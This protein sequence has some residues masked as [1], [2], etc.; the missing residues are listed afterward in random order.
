MFRKNSLTV[1]F[2]L[3]LLVVVGCSSIVSAASDLTGSNADAETPQEVVEN[4]YTWLLD[5][6]GNRAE[7]EFHNPM[8][9]RAYRDSNALSQ[10]YIKELDRLMESDTP[11]GHDPLLCA[12]DVPQFVEIKEMAIEG[13][14]AVAQMGSSFPNHRFEVHL[15]KIEGTWKITSI[16]CKQ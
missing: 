2:M 4:F 13:D 9:E 14:Q 1:L 12:Q 8:V 10:S 7:G 11:L 5:Y 6:I 3:L 16:V 15:D